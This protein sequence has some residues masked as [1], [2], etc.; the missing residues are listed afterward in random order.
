[1]GIHHAVILS[2]LP[3]VPLAGADSAPPVWQVKAAPLRVAVTVAEKPSEPV[4]GVLALLPDGGLLPGTFVA[5]EVRDSAGRVLESRLA[6]H[7]PGE[8]AGVVFAPPADGRAWIYLK[9]SNGPPAQAPGMLR[10]G[11][12]LYTR[13]IAKPSLEAAAAMAA[14]WPPGRGATMLP[15]K[16]VGHRENPMGPDDNYLSW[17]TGWFQLEK[18]ATGRFATVS[19]DGSEIR[20]DGQPIVSWPGTHNR[21]EGARGQHATDIVVA[22]GWHHFDY[23]HFNGDGDRELHALLLWHPQDKKPKTLHVTIARELLG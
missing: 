16:Q 5:A 3:L 22:A 13:N 11:L 23:L 8:G 10:P 6:W 7:N 21:G 12:F 19:D 4:R 2:V 17:Y 1:M 9:P 15:V 20:L 18:S 14:E